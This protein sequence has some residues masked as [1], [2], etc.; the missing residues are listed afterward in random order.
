MEVGVHMHIFSELGETFDL[1]FLT[2]LLEFIMQYYNRICLWEGDADREYKARTFVD[3]CLALFGEFLQLTVCG[4]SRDHK[5]DKLC[6]K[7]GKFGVA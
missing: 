7:A 1:F 3:I 5:V 4:V 2:Q 6:T